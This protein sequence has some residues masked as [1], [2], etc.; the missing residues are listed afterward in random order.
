M[1]V[2]VSFSCTFQVQYS[3]YKTAQYFIQRMIIVLKS[4]YNHFDRILIRQILFDYIN[5]FY[6]QCIRTS[7]IRHA[8][9]S[10]V[11][12]YGIGTSLL[13]YEI[14]L[15]SLVFIFKSCFRVMVYIFVR[16]R[17]YQNRIEKSRFFQG[18]QTSILTEEESIT[19]DWSF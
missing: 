16:L 8:Y 11:L 4:W 19:P 18:I 17:A 10:L 14:K 1:M 12:H 7:Q 13:W 9:K 5:W 2:T 3:Y 6:L 15:R